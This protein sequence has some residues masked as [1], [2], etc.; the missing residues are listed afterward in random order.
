MSSHLFTPFH[1]F[2]GEHFPDVFTRLVNAQRKRD[3]PL[4]CAGINVTFLLLEMLR[5]TDDVRRM[6]PLERRSSSLSHQQIDRDPADQLAAVALGLRS[7]LSPVCH[8][9][10]ARARACP[11]S[12]AGRRR[13][14]ARC[15]AAAA[16]V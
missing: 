16:A 4:A 3:Y 7:T 14:G 15:G 11:Q 13:R 2:S 8:H 5:L 6:H 9:T 1:T 10:H 12:G